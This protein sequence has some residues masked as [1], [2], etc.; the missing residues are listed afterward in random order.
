MTVVAGLA[1]STAR[2]RLKLSLMSS[3]SVLS[4]QLKAKVARKKIRMSRPIFGCASVWPHCAKRGRRRRAGFRLPAFGENKIG[5]EKIRRAQRR[6]RPAGRG[7]PA[8]KFQ[9]HAADGRAENKAE[10]ERHADEAHPF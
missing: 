5:E 6:R 2:P 3:G 7:G 8:I 1:T 9:R 10:A 4:K